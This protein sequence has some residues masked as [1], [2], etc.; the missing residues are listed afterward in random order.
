MTNKPLPI[1]DHELCARM[2]KTF[3]A[4]VNDALRSRGF[5]F[6]TLP[7]NIMPLRD[8][9]KVCGVAFTIKGAKNLTL[10]GE[11]EKRAEMLEALTPGS[12]AVWD[13]D[14]DDESAQWGEIMTMAAKKRG[15]LGAVVDGGIRDTGKILGLKFPVFCRYRSSN[16]MLGRF[17]MVDFQI[18]VKVGSVIVK[19]GDIVFGD[20][21]GVLVVPRDIAYDVLLEAERIAFGEEDIKKQVESG[22]SPSEVVRNGG[23]F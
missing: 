20:I 7:N 8:E 4:A 9:M 1:P 2:E 19:P 21:D 15:C 13:T 14:S 5:L 12:V 11:M 16:G 10:E 3:T 22:S 6:Q 23:Y 17:R 18:P